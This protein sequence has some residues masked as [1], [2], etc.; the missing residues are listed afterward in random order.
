MSQIIN[1][2]IPK[3]GYPANV[4]TNR[5]PTVYPHIQIDLLDL[6]QDLEFDVSKTG[7]ITSFPQGSWEELNRVRDYI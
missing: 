7:Q 1:D 5:E 2:L 4:Q 6:H 3:L